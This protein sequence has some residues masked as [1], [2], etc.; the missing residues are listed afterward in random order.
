MPMETSEGN[1]K[2]AV[3]SQMSWMSCE[4]MEAGNFGGQHGPEATRGDRR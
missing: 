1:G 2:E 4:Q 3:T